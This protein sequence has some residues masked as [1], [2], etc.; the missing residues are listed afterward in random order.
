MS[1][2]MIIRIEP[3]LRDKVG[4]LARAEGKTTSQVVRSLLEEYVRSRDMGAY[5]DDLWDRIGTKLS[6]RGVGV[7]EVRR[8][9][10]SARAGK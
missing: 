8:A 1:T 2:Q 5:V 3:E 7:K 4:S 9:I 6:S 10:R